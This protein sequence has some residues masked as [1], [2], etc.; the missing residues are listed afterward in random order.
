MAQVLS[1]ES[2]EKALVVETGPNED[3]AAGYAEG[4]A[5]G[6]AE[7]E[8]DSAALA[9]SFVQSVSDAEF[10]YAEASS[11]LLRSLR[12][13][14][15]A[16]SEKI[17]PH[18]VDA[19]FASQ[20]ANTLSNGAA[21]EIG[22]PLSVHVSTDQYEAV[23]AAL[24]GLPIQVDVKPDVSLPALTAW[25]G[26]DDAECLFDLSSITAEIDK[27]LGAIETEFERTIEHG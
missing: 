16:L 4:L 26:R 6:R 19:G 17:L 24:S 7:A 13:L 9:S 18:C 1:L 20:L 5:A 21:A 15:Q 12:P 8:A 14:F 25:I 23:L 3:Y 10:T 27:M 22:K 11:Q 2:F